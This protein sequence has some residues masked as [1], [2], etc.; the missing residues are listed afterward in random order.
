MV[1]VLVYSGFEGG[2]WWCWSAVGLKE[3]G[4][5]V[6]VVI[7]VYSEFERFRKDDEFGGDGCWVWVL[8][9]VGAGFGLGL[10]WFADVDATWYATWQYC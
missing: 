8:V 9:W 6:G 1:V 3:A 5:G 7:L 2:R 10:V 4:D